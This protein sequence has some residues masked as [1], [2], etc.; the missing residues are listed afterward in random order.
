[1]DLWTSLEYGL[2]IMIVIFNI[3]RLLPNHSWY[4]TKNCWLDMS[5]M[6]PWIYRTP[7][8]K[9]SFLS[10][11]QHGELE[12]HNHSMRLQVDAVGFNR[13]ITN[14]ISNAAT[15][16]DI[17]SS[18]CKTVSRWHDKNKWQII[19]SPTLM[20]SSHSHTPPCSSC[21][22]LDRYFRGVHDLN[23][24][25]LIIRGGSWDLLYNKGQ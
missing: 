4:E 8:L 24:R 5:N 22:E 13:E 14:K 9:L 25:C 17:G 21:S 12:F 2:L 1:M 15:Y 18:C 16:F 10:G 23:H 20:I 3:E 19:E 11:S 7:S 6:C